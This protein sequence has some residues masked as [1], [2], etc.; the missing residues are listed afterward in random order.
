MILEIDKAFT[1]N[2]H[3]VFDFFQRPGMGLYIPL[4]QREYSWD[5]DNIN[6]LTEDIT[7]GIEALCENE[8]QELRFLGTIITIVQ[9]DKSKIDPID[10]KAVPTSVEYIIDGQQRLTTISIFTLL[11]YDFIEETKKKI[12]NVDEDLMDEIF[13]ACNIWQKKLLNIFSLDLG[14]GK[15]KRK[16][17]IIRGQLDRWVKDGEVD[18]NYRS[19]LSNL[20]AK[21]LF[22]YFADD[23]EV[24]KP[25]M[26]KNTVVGK[27]FNLIQSWIKNNVLGAHRSSNNEFACAKDLLIKVKEEFIWDNER[28]ELREIVFN[29]PNHKIYNNLCG[30]VQLFAVCHYLLERCCFTHIIPLNEDWAFDMFQSLNASGTPLT[31]IETFKPLVVNSAEQNGSTYKDSD[32]SK[33]FERIENIFVNSKSASDKSKKTNELIT[34][35]RI[36][37]DGKKIQNHFSS[38]RKWLN[39]RFDE[40]NTFQEKEVYMKLFGYYSEFLNKY[41][42]DKTKLDFIPESDDKELIEIL[43]LFLKESKHFMAVTILGRLYSQIKMGISNSL[44][45]FKKG[46]R[47]ISALYVFYRSNH[48]NSGLDQVY[49][50]YFE[51][52]KEI[53]WEKKGWKYQNVLDVQDFTIYV[54]EIL[55]KMFPLIMDSES[56]SENSN[57][58]LRYT[59]SK[60]ICKLSL[61]VSS[62][63]T[64]ASKE[65]IGMLKEGV[66]DSRL[67]LTLKHWN[68]EKLSTIEHIAPQESND[69]WDET[70]YSES[71]YYDSI[72][73]LTLLPLSINASIGNRPWNEKFIYYKFLFVK[74]KDSY[75]ELVHFANDNNVKLNESTLEALKS[76]PYYEHV[77]SIVSVGYD[78]QWDANLVKRRGNNILKFLGD[79]V[80]SLLEK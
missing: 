57:K 77:D 15:I 20:L 28:E 58:Y 75:E 4:Y 45:D 40:M 53:N 10:T 47:T 14:K 52:N 74:D 59:N 64:I 27:N 2:G 35:F 80:Y 61:F 6:Q 8:S 73:N 36:A 5:K 1:T 70:L 44:E 24:D 66:D 78:G 18:E 31:A 22:Y 49:R 39:S 51:G 17:Q 65:E 79:F 34:S 69:A 41:W 16:P 29:N 62:H 26:S 63:N 68:S 71:T 48:S 30:L 23:Q 7:K 46:V 32:I 21:F 11:L 55:K 13:E 72:G 19:E 9:G 50:R 60:S 56:F 37:I 67:F 76:S 42:F 25:K 38:Q 3:T 12:K 54:K 33:S 43:F